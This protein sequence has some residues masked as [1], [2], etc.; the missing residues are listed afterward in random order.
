ME[1]IICNTDP[2]SIEDAIN[3]T[4]VTRK[5]QKTMLIILIMSASLS[6]HRLEMA[7]P[8]FCRIIAGAIV[9]DD[10]RSGIPPVSPHKSSKCAR[11]HQGTQ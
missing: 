6:E 4:A 10:L 2:I 7:Y 3:L 5:Y 1:E 11:H 8:N 9:P